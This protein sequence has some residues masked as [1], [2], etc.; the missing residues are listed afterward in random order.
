[1]PTGHWGHFDLL[2]SEHWT[3]LTSGEGHS[4]A[5]AVAGADSDQTPYGSRYVLGGVVL[6]V[7]TTLALSHWMLALVA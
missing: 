7:V 4:V 6:V 2:F 3:A 1:V 5:A